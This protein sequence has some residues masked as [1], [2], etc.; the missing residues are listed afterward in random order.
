MMLKRKLYS[1]LL[2]WKEECRGSKALLI[3]GAR[4]VGKSTLCEEFGKNE[5]QTCLVIDFAKQEK[6]VE[7]YFRLYLNDL[8]TFFMLLSTYFGKKLVER[9]TLIVFDEVQRFPRAREAIKYLVA[10]GRYDYIETGSLISI[11]DNVKDIVLPSEERSVKMFPLDFEEFAW[12]MGEDLLMDYIRECFAKKEPLERTLHNKAMLLFRQYILV[13]GMPKPVVLF[14]ENAKNFEPADKEKRDI[15]KL[16]RNDIMKIKAGYRTKV[17]GVFDQIPGLLSKHEKRVVFKEIAEGSY[18]D[19]FSE[20]FFWLDDS[21][22]CNE[23][24]LTNDPNAGL[25]LN[26]DRSYVKCY[27]GDTGLLVSHTFDENE[28]LK[29]EVYSQI[30]NHNLAL[31]EGM[32]YE[33][34]IAQML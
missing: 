21:M 25:S 23:C 32:L 11:R 5:Y 4:R 28:L 16:Y 19:Q 31:N 10:D 17:L 22:I 14:L 18:Y 2:A 1:A 15:L 34:V 29:E 33:N 27:M 7:E 20:A 12:A 30:L 9:D 13:G 26:E 6:E 3:E 8:D 24:F